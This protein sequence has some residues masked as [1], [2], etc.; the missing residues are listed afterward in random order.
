MA[1][2]KT[3]LTLKKNAGAGA[4]GAKKV[5]NP[6]VATL[7]SADTLERFTQNFMGD[8]GRAEQFL[9]GALTLVNNN[10]NLANATP[11]SV[12]AGLALVSLT[13]LSIN[14]NY[15][16]AYLI[17][18]AGKAQVQIGYKGYIKLMQNT[19][20]YENIIMTPVYEGELVKG[21]RFTEEYEFDET[22]RVSDVVIGYYVC[23]KL[24]NGFVKKVYWTKDAVIKH[25][26]RFS[27]SYGNGPWKTDFDAMACKT[28]FKSVV[29][30]APMSE[31]MEK[32]IAADGVIADQS[33]DNGDPE[34]ID[35]DYETN[36]D[37]DTD[38]DVRID[39]SESTDIGA[40]DAGSDAGALFGE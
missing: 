15:G 11:S 28:V 40:D 36:I 4:T 9:S 1:N 17:E 13:G 23:F 20:L 8:K 33:T 32:A 26:K 35:V 31:R 14:P 5:L 34:V 38:D 24:L 7:K 19:G 16:Y 39:G 18:Y 37:I 3:G 25:A 27:K 29:K 2:A 12:M 10:K 21:N 30:F 22:K 6:L